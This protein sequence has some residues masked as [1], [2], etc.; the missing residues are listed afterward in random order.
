MAQNNLRYKQNRLQQLRGFC[1]T[2][3]F[4]SMSKAAEKLYLGQ[5]SI[6]LQIKA[7]E[8]ELGAQL[9]K[10]TGSR[11]E[12]TYDGKQLFELARP[13]VDGIDRLDEHFASMRES[14]DRGT[15]TIATGGS[16]IQ[17]LLPKVV[18]NFTKEYPLVDVRLLNVYGKT[19][20][21]LLRE[22]SVDFVVGPQI[23][24]PSD[25]E[26]SPLVTYAPMLIAPLNHP[27]AARKRVT[28][29]DI[30]KFPMI[31]PPETHSTHRLISTVLAEQSLD[32]D[33][34]LEI[35]SYDVIKKYV[36]LGIG[37]SIVMSH[38]LSGVD[39]LYTSPLD[40]YFP[41]RTYG[42]VYGKH[43][44]LPPAPNRFLRMMLEDAGPALSSRMAVS[45]SNSSCATN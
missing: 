43:N 33:V 2:A 37:I 30:V 23:K 27:L 9:F 16:T 32:Y 45:S 36:E 8:R 40:R 42:V 31:L 6:S 14:E 13:L 20:L 44:K 24:M 17:Y 39:Q 5:P 34:K 26:F 11:L 18:A 21:R 4:N 7:L 10:R 3:R 28:L 29:K 12:L 25:L 41:K 19:R 1:Y 22:G 15:V 35:G 38:C